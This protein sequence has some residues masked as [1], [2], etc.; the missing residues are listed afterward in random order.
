MTLKEQK[1]GR[2]YGFFY[3]SASQKELE[4][5]LYPIRDATRTLANMGL[6]LELKAGINPKDY[7]HDSELK[8]LSEM[9][10]RQ[11][12]NYTIT[13]TLPDATNQ[14]TA[15]ELGDV[16]NAYYQ[17]PLMNSFHKGEA[18]SIGGIVYKEAD[19]YEFLE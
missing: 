18:K 9:A 2:A 12:N 11:D 7:S 4:A 16:M 10:V 17:S 19:R 14:R 15:K 8:E 1:M 6:E 5:E 3:S 13:A